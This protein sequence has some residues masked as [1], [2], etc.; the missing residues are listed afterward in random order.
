MSLSIESVNTKA[1]KATISG[2]FC[3]LA[4][5][6]WFAS[7]PPHISLF[8][9]ILLTVV[10]MFAA[11]IL[12]GLVVALILGCITRVTTGSWEGSMH[13]YAWGVFISPMLAFFA[14]NYA[15]KWV[16]SF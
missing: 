1:S 15:I 16:A 2:W 4:Y 5:F 11:S 13:G 6:N 8:G 10:G 7:N 14:A 3:G 9:H 12:I